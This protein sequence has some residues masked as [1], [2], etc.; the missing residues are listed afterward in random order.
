MKIQTIDRKPVENITELLKQG[1]SFRISEETENYKL[2]LPFTSEWWASDH[3]SGE[4]VLMTE[5][6]PLFYLTGE[7]LERGAGDVNL[8][9][10]T[11]GQSDILEG[12]ANYTTY[13]ETME[14]SS[15]PYVALLQTHKDKFIKQR[16]EIADTILSNSERTIQSMARD[17]SFQEIQKIG[18]QI[19]EKGELTAL[20]KHMYQSRSKEW[21]TQHNKWNESYIDKAIDNTIATINAIY[22]EK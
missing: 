9:N 2:D 11:R 6:S 10:T 15:I 12:G 19:P 17:H 21:A 14:Q 13:S 4:H 22:T 18:Q 3:Q 8:T 5:I 16:N 20:V 1:G 7:T